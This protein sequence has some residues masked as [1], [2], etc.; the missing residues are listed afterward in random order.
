MFRYLALLWHERN[1]ADAS[2]ATSLLNRIVD[3]SPDLRIS[4]ECAGMTV[5]SN[6]VPGRVATGRCHLSGESGIVLGTLFRAPGLGEEASNARLTSLE[7]HA[8]RLI[9]D[10]GGQ[11]LI[12]NYWGRY[13]AFI[14]DPTRGAKLVIRDPMGGLPCF[15]CKVGGVSVAFSC[16]EDCL[17]TGM[18]QFTLNWQHVAARVALGGWDMPDTGLQQCRELRPGRRMQLSRGRE[19]QRELWSRSAVAARGTLDDLDLAADQLRAMTQSCTNSWASCYDSALVD[20]S[21]GLDS[22][23]VAACLARAPSKPRVT[24]LKFHDAYTQPG[25]TRRAQLVADHVGYE[26]VDIDIQHQAIPVARLMAA[27]LSVDLDLDVGVC[28]VLDARNHLARERGAAA[29]FNGNPG[30]VLFGASTKEFG[31]LDYVHRHGF[32]NRVLKI[33]L[34]VALMTDR[35][36]WSMVAE[37]L[38]KPQ[39]M[40]ERDLAKITME[41]RKLPSDRAR[42]AVVEKIDLYCASAVAAGAPPGTSE[43]LSSFT[44]GMQYYN[45]FGT[46]L[47]GGSAEP[48]PVYVLRSQPLVELCLRIPPYIKNAGG[49]ERWVARQAFINAIPTQITS[50]FW[51]DPAPNCGQITL[52]QSMA[53]FREFLN[54]GMLMKQHLLDEGKLR[55]ALAVGPVRRSAY[56]SEVH[57]YLI[58]ELWVR[59]MSNALEKTRRS[60][61][62]PAVVHG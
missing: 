36:W 19:V 37:G 6:A 38:R 5:L 24:A 31:V 34:D 61:E 13:V 16:L 33:A 52:L 21:G 40:S 58:A 30:D 46:A 32:D 62:W 44:R 8:S 23:I 41:V 60:A 48:E 12:D 18:F 47:K 11:E 20:I 43:F 54:D 15:I 2:T 53:T 22:S 42:Q 14:N 50:T 51:K 35:S 28:E 3:V 27:D 57:D 25:E 49:R 39:P 7:Q 4:F 55:E 56:P 26:L 59:R 1:E 9:V 10:S 29:T 17:S 45:H